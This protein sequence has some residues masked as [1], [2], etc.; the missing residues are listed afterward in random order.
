MRNLLYKVLKEIKI[1]H[2]LNEKELLLL[3]D[4]VDIKSYE[5]NEYILKENTIGREMYVIVK[6]SV[7][8]TKNNKKIIDL[9]EKDSIGEMSLLDVQKRTASV[10]CNEKTYVAELK[11]NS[12]LKIY[13]IDKDMYIKIILNIAREFSRR[14]RHMDEIYV[15]FLQQNP[16]EIIEG[17]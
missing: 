11:Y 4:M 6:G 1:F 10:S 2:A 17:N 14:L 16:K 5:K 12:L 9:Y 8:V 15:E 13:K 7:K 3:M